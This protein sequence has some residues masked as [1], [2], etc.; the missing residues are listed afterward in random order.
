LTLI[1]AFST[2]FAIVLLGERIEAIDIICLLLVVGGVGL[3]VSKPA[4]H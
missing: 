1:P 3:V 2:G 4:R